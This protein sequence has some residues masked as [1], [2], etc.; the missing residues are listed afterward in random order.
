M[1]LT[2]FQNYNST[3][4][5]KALFPVIEYDKCKWIP[6]QYWK[7]WL[8]TRFCLFWSLLDKYSQSADKHNHVDIDE[9][10][11]LSPFQLSDGV[12]L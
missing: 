5:Y 8:Q 6:W 1:V 9:P 10:N 3:Q 12:V 2:A 11:T 7:N 4:L